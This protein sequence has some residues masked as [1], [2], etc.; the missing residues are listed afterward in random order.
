MNNKK[1]HKQSF[2]R[3]SIRQILEQLH[4]LR[5][6]KRKDALEGRVRVELRE[7]YDNLR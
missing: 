1:Q 4:Y 5:D 3:Q 7:N 6:Q 2:N